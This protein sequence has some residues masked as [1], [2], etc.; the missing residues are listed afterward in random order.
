MKISI[1]AS[2]KAQNA[3]ISASRSARSCANQMS[4]TLTMSHCARSGCRQPL[5]A[6]WL[7]VRVALIWFAHDRALRLAEI[8]AFW[9]FDD[10]PMLIFITLG[11]SDARI[12]KCNRLERPEDV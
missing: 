2:S 5:R 9:A 4:A 10:A 8:S 1:G 12:G 7:I 11:Q 6:Q 3:L